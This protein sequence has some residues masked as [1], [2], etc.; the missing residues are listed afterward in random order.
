MDILESSE[1]GKN[2]M[3]NGYGPLTGREVGDSGQRVQLDY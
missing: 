3:S 1:G 2:A